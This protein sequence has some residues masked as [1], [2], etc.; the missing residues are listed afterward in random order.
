[1][2][3]SVRGRRW[4]LYN[5][6]V[7]TV[8]VGLL[9]G[10]VYSRRSQFEALGD[11]P[12]TQ[13][14]LVAV[15]SALGFLLNAME[16]G[17]LYRVMGAR[18]GY[19]ENWLLYSAGQAG[20]YL[21]GQIG[22]LYRFKYLRDVHEMPYS[23]STAAYSANFVITIFATGVTGLFA[24]VCLGLTDGTWSLLLTV[25]LVFL[26]AV[27]GAAAVVPVSPKPRETRLGSAW[28]RLGQGW[29]RA[30][31]ARAAAAVVFVLEAA[32]YGLAAWRLDIAFGWLGVDDSYFFFLAIAPIAALATFVAITPAGLGIREL[33]IAAAVVALGRPFSDG[34]LGSSAERAISLAVVLIAG[35]PSFIVTSRALHRSAEARSARADGTRRHGDATEVSGGDAAL[36]QDDRGARDRRWRFWRRM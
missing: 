13:I 26:I 18:I 12:P 27:A 31:R 6:V 17:L 11:I 22:T 2:T 35:I 34:I 25:G 19:G 20:N 1:M 29:E 16:F 21:P 24:L 36:A 28:V 8:A 9:G 4:W 14:L 5:V 23:I 7:P 15:L 10:Y 30:R 33:A 32:R 3:R